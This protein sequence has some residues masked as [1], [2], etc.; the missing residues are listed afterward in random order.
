MEN[1]IKEFDQYLN[2]LVKSYPKAI[3]PIHNS[4]STLTEVGAK[5]KDFFQ[6]AENKI[7]ELISKNPLIPPSN[8]KFKLMERQVHY[9]GILMQGHL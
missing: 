1:I 5:S 9:H 6:K 8:I 2:E 3:T 4:P 7:N